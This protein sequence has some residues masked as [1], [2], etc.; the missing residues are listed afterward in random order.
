MLQREEMKNRKANKII[1]FFLSFFQL[2]ELAK[3]V[4]YGIAYLLKKYPFVILKLSGI[5]PVVYSFIIKSV[6]LLPA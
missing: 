3:I 2:W 1:F 4:L 6:W 5:R